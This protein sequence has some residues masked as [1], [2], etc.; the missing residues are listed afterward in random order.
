MFK[1]RFLTMRTFLGCGL[2]ELGAVCVA[3]ELRN[4]Y[5]LLMMVVLLA[6]GCIESLSM[7][8]NRR[9]PIRSSLIRLL[10]LMDELAEL[11]KLSPEKSPNGEVAISAE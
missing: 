10:F 9:E 8:K 6:A 11:T 2:A 7:A 4:R 1:E 3:P 5:F